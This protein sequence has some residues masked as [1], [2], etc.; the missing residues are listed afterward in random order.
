M[1]PAPQN[2]PFPV[3]NAVVAVS[4]P[5]PVTGAPN[6]PRSGET[7][8]RRHAQ[9][10]A[11]HVPSAHRHRCRAARELLAP[12]GRIL[13]RINA[14]PLLHAG[15]TRIEAQAQTKTRRPPT[16]YLSPRSARR[17]AVAWAAIHASTSCGRIRTA[18]LTRTW[19][20][21]PWAISR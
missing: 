16:T 12:Y 6:P 19:V 5:T 11:H 15:R 7:R 18:L 17:R 9:H 21:A 10:G 2:R 3:K 13:E 14:E 20:R 1:S 8:R 4:A